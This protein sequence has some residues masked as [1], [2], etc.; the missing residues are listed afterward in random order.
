MLVLLFCPLFDP[1]SSEF[2][3]TG[4]GRW[5]HPGAPVR[6]FHKLNVVFCV[7]FFVALVFVLFTTYLIFLLY[8]CFLFPC[9]QRINYYDSMGGGGKTVTN[10]LLLWLE[11][12]DEDKNKDNATFDPDEWTTVGTKVSTTPQQVRL[13]QVACCTWGS[14]F[15]RG[16]GCFIVWFCTVW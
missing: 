6:W 9:A 8:C 2:W 3:Q 11:D 14:T 12:E 13:A 4:A 15:F 16:R 1:F 5:S 10:S 7:L